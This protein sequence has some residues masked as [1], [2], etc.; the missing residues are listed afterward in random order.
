MRVKIEIKDGEI[1]FV[2]Y[3]NDYYFKVKYDTEEELEF[4]KK[5]AEKF[6]AN[7]RRGKSPL[8]E[9]ERSY[10][11]F[12]VWEITERN[13]AQVAG[14]EK[15]GAAFHLDHIVPILYGYEHNIS[16]HLIGGLDNLRIISRA[17][18][19]RK[20]NFITECS[21]KVLKLWGQI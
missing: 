15:R 11:W 5:Y 3:L 10:Y 18:N 9:F 17:E 1:K 4:Y 7:K 21:K 6:Y 13:A 2:K 20:V 12:V 16:P 8:G 19:M 14:I